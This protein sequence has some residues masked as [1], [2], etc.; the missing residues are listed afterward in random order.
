MAGSKRP[1][2]DG[3]VT[4]LAALCFIHS[5]LS[6]DSGLGVNITTSLQMIFQ[7]PLKCQGPVQIHPLERRKQTHSVTFFLRVRT[8]REF[9]FYHQAAH[10]A[11][12]SSVGQESSVWVILLPRG[13]GTM[14]GADL[15]CHSWEGGR[16]F[17]HL[18]R[19]DWRCC[20]VSCNREDSPLLQRINWL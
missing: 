8:G 3:V 4:C 5:F 18:V 14:P 15:G 10:S 16:C 7:M 9:T 1:H 6:L 12:I 2:S 13:H 20:S 17:R 19:G 11:S